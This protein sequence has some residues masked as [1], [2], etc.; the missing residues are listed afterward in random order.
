MC[1]AI[2]II[3]KVVVGLNLY[4]V[5]LLKKKFSCQNFNHTRDFSTY[6]LLHVLKFFV[7]PIDCIALKK[8]ILG[9]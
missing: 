5:I 8:C 3:L 6:I 1:Y 4:C 2:T 7:L 9:Y